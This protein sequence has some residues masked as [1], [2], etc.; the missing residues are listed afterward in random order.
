[1]NRKELRKKS[2]IERIVQR[3]NDWS[4]QVTDE[5]VLAAAFLFLVIATLF[6]KGL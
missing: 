3:V 2:K 4:L 1:M 5:K 6:F